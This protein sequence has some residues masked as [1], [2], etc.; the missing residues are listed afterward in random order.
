MDVVKSED[1]PAGEPWGFTKPGPRPKKTKNESESEEK[2][3]SESIVSDHSLSDDE[4]EVEALRLED[5][6]ALEK[7][8]SV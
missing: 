3:K 1:E 6:Q 8:I 5:L 2:L 7:K 4:D